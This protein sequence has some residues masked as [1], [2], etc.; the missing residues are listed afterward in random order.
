MPAY[1][2]HRPVDTR[3]LLQKLKGTHI[4]LGERSAEKLKKD[5]GE[6]VAIKGKEYFHQNKE[7]FKV[8]KQLNKYGNIAHAFNSHSPIRKSPSPKKV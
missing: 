7:D 4:R 6:E 3:E 2:D 8:I 1:P 5:F